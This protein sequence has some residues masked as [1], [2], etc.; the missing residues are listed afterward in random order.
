MARAG[1][2][3]RTGASRADLPERWRA[4]RRALFS[5][6]AAAV[7]LGGVVGVAVSRHQA[8]V[9]APSN[10]VQP[11][12]KAVP[13]A[14]AHIPLVDDD[15][16]PSTLAALH[17]RIVILGDFMTSCQ[18]E[19]PITTGA[20]LTVERSLAAEHL[21]SRVEVVE[22]SVDPWRDTPSRLQAYRKTFGVPFTLM[23]GSVENLARLWSFFGVEYNRVPESKPPDIDWQTGRPYTFDIDHS[24]DAFVLGDAGDERELVVGNADVN[25]KLPKALTSLL[26]AQGRQE[27]RNAGLGSWTPSDMLEAVGTVLH[28]TIP[29]VDTP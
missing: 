15:G 16:Q 26:D 29:L 27:L 3:H 25:G 18:E 6:L 9:A 21:L 28:R 20:L 24:D 19:C 23:T 14:V 5:T 17:G 4:R 8:T 11:T 12:D 10:P 7:V 2:A 13:V 1:P 22:V